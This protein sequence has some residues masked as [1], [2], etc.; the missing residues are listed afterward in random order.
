MIEDFIAKDC[1]LTG[2]EL[3][4][5]RINQL[6]VQVFVRHH[7]KNGPINSEMVVDCPIVIRSIADTLF[8]TRQDQARNE[9]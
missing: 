9:Q 8:P 7:A 1:L 4:C 3:A 6:G 2:Q 5:S